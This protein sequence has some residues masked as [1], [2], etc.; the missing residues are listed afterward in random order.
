MSDQAPIP[1]PTHGR[2]N[3]SIGVIVSLMLLGAILFGGG[4]GAGIYFATNYRI[5]PLT[6]EQPVQATTY[7]ESTPAEYPDSMASTTEPN[8][9]TQ[10]PSAAQATVPA[11]APR[12]AKAPAGGG[13]FNFQFTPGETLRY[14]LVADVGGE[15]A[16]SIGSAPVDM[17]LTTTMNLN[18][19]SVDRDGTGDLRLEFDNTN[20]DGDFMGSPY[21]MFLN[22]SE[23]NIEMDGKSYVNSKEGKGSVDGLPQAQYFL[24]PI[25]MR[26][27]R[28]GEVLSV[29]G[30]MNMESMLAALPLQ[31]TPEFPMGNLDPNTQW[32]STIA[33]PI[34]G[35]AEPAQATVLNTMTGYTNVKG[36]RCAAIKQEIQSQQINGKLNSPAGAFGEQMGFGMPQFILDGQNMLYF[37]VDRGQL[38]RSDMDLAVKIEIG[39]ALGQ[40]GDAIN[41]IISQVGSVAMEGLPEFDDMREKLESGESLLD[42]NVAVKAT[43]ELQN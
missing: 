32:E 9:E 4:I 29:S 22:Q 23:Q 6:S 24:E 2:K 12:S 31:A 38:V 17:K 20:F 25:D 19:K 34:P 21:A 1:V 7:A 39:K 11:S 16:E 33:L 42:M 27:A 10:T 15:G 5:I 40:A 37:D 30:G 26:V 14:A 8:L 18:T 13:L 28:N 3:A 36:R 43:M 41:A 35:F